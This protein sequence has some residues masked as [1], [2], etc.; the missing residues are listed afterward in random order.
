MEWHELDVRKAQ[1]L[2]IRHQLVREFAISEIAIVFFRLAATI[3]MH[4]IR[5]RPA[6]HGRCGW[7]DRA[8]M[9]R[10]SKNTR[11]VWNCRA[12]T[13]RD[14]RFGGERIGFLGQLVAKSILSSYL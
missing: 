10:R 9:R 14:F 4:F 8:S 5:W 12:G 7:R 13:R 3:R 2:N 11:R 6:R 1:V